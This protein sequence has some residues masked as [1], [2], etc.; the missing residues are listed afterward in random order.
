MSFFKFKD[1]K[2]IGAED[3]TH[4]LDAKAPFAVRESFNLLRTNLMYTITEND[5][6][7]VYAITSVLE[8]SGK[9]TV[10]TNLALSFSQIG[11][12]VLLVDGDMRCPVV[13]KFF[14]LD[15][16][17]AGLSELIPGIEKDVVL[18]DI[19]PGL[20]L[21][22]SGRV[23][24]NPSELLTSPRLKKLIDRW[25]EEYDVIFIDFPPIGVVTDALAV[26]KEITGYIFCVRSGRNIAKEIMN[27]V[28]SME[29]IG[30]KV[31]GMVLNDYN[32]KGSSGHYSNSRYSKYGKY[33]KYNRYSRYSKYS[34]SQYERSTLSY[35]AESESD[36]GKETKDKQ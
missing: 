36:K 21:I 5:S 3:T 14:D 18:K 23:P 4:L 17:R 15:E 22:T 9:S 29:Q 35:S 11:K 1:K 26:C 13:H 32:L 2:N 8:S 6:T 27:A 12:K 30:G 31:V 24:P 34:M 25:K 28:E 10:I 7:P 20:D 16:K 33:S 19:R